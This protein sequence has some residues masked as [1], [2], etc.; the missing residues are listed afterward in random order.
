MPTTTA[1]ESTGWLAPIP[2]LYRRDPE[3]RYALGD[4]TFPVSITGVLA[5]QK[6]DFAMQRIRATEHI[7]APRGNTTHRAM[8]CFCSA[9]APAADAAA[10]ASEL[11]EHAAGDYSDWIT[12][13]ITHP[14][15]TAVQV[16]ASE[17]PTCCITR[18]IAGTYDTA[19][20]QADGR[21]VIADLKTLGANGSTY[22]TRAQLGGYMALEATH[23]VFYDAGQTIWAWPGK[24]EFSPLYSRAECL[25]AWAAAWATYKA[26]VCHS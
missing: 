20:N 24:T 8:E 19:F 3:H 21:R 25:L 5:I 9:R 7:W 23:G 15:W 11:A 1:P 6:S 13:L 26:R 18:R 4:I 2:G 10:F 14:R 22:C 17:R 16:I 12:P